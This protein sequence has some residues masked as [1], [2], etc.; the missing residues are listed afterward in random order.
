MSLYADLL[1]AGCEI[2]HHES[3]LYA[4]ATEQARALVVRHAARATPFRS[5]RDGRLWLEIPFAWDP[6]WDAAADRARWSP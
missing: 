5:P 6:Y 3:D 1:A 2:D 4:R